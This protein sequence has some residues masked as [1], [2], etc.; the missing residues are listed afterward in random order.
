MATGEGGSNLNKL[1]SHL[2]IPTYRVEGYSLYS[3]AKGW[4][5]IITNGDFGR[6]PGYEGQPGGGP[7]Q[8]HPSSEKGSSKTKCSPPTPVKKTRTGSPSPKKDA[9]YL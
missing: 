4:F 3:Q 5:Q 6:E 2:P 1:I 9:E 7:A 8:I